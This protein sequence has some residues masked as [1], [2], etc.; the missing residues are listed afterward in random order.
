[1]VVR[2]DDGSTCDLAGTSS[3]KDLYNEVFWLST[4]Q[5]IRIDR[6]TADLACRPLQSWGAEGKWYLAGTVPMMGWVLLRQT[7]DRTARKGAMLPY[8]SYAIANRDSHAFTSG[9][10]L[11]DTYGTNAIVAPGANAVCSTVRHPSQ[12]R[13]ALGC[14]NM[15][16]GIAIPV[17]SELNGYIVA[18]VS[19]RSAVVVAE[20]PKYGFWGSL[21]PELPDYFN[22]IV[23]DI[24]SGHRL[25]SMK[26]PGQRAVS[27]SLRSRYFC[28]ALSPNGDLL[29]TGGNGNV[30][31]LRLQ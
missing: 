2:L 21:F 9:V 16:D 15:P 13:P 4:D 29:A 30:L 20:R 19:D 14:W 18:G 11:M 8:N 3:S 17:A 7:A 23:F 26:A 28:Y 5:L 25:A 1:M 22:L 24:R 12:D 6:A 27:S 10:S 31:L